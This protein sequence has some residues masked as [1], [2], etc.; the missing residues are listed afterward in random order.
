MLKATKTK[1]GLHGWGLKSAQ[2]AAKKYDSMI[3]TTYM[4]NIF[5]AVATLSYHGVTM[6]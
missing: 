5:R 6:E 1:N 3:Q 2:T 4:V